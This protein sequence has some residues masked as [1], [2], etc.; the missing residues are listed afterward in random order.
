MERHGNRQALRAPLLLP[1]AVAAVLDAVQVD[2][3]QVAEADR[4][5]QLD[6]A[7]RVRL[8]MQHPLRRH[9][10]Y[11]MD[12]TPLVR[13][14][15]WRGVNSTSMPKPAKAC[16]HVPSLSMTSSASWTAQKQKTAWVIAPR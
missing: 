4:V 2:P 7:D 13:R 9:S 8:R 5:G 14:S 11:K 16:R 12:S 1:R 15:R 10:P 3:A 6:R